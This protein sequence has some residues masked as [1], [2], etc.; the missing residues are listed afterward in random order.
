MAK[1][2]NRWQGIGRL[3]RDP[4]S[5]SM[6]DGSPISQFT[7]ACDDDYKDRNGQ[8]V[9]APEFIPIVAYGKVAEICNKFL[10]KGKQVFVEGKFTTRKWDENG[11]ARYMTEIKLEN[12]QMLGSR[13]DGAGRG[14]A[15][16]PAAAA[17]VGRR[18][19]QPTLDDD[20][21]F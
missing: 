14:Q 6:P 12:M 20:I 13:D 4:E 1:S 8:K 15:P 11:T 18:P 17:P 16:A 7:I 3:T 9:D 5:R 2:L 10:S 19:A 21:P